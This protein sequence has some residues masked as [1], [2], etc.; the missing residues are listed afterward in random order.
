[1]RRKNSISYKQ[2]RYLREILSKHNNYF[3]SR[4]NFHDGIE[5]LLL[6]KIIFLVFFDHSFFLKNIS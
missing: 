1:M 6:L 5:N 3:K 2:Y 4:K